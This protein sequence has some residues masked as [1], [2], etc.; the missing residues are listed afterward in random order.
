M[1]IS[2]TSTFRFL[3]SL[4]AITASVSACGGQQQTPAEPPAETP[5]PSEETT[6]PSSTEGTEPSA[7]EGT[8]AGEE[9]EHTMP[10]GGNMSGHHHE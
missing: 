7:T 5:A 9:Q 2:N 6:E 4:V 1:Y 10:D 3:L 8:E